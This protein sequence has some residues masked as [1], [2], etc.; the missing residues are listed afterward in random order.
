MWFILPYCISKG[1][2]TGF[3]LVFSIMEFVSAT[4]A[5]TS[6][7]GLSCALDF[8]LAFTQNKNYQHKNLSC[9]AS[10]V[11]TC[12]LPRGGSLDSY[13]LKEI[14]SKIPLSNKCALPTILHN[15]GT[16]HQKQHP[17]SYFHTGTAILSKACREEESPGSG[18]C[19]CSGPFWYPLVCVSRL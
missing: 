9:A 10:V 4:E 14:S 3:I 11:W 16:K 6:E 7:H 5:L 15:S 2:D 18:S 12:F 1:R 8:A 13:S 17:F 19:R